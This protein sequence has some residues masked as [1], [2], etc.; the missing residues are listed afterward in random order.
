MFKN[1]ITIAF[2][3]LWKNKRFTAINILGLAI[4]IS[5]SLVIY[6]LVNYHFTFDKFEKDGGR[7]YRVV[8]NFSFSG[9]VY[10]NS[11]V[12]S[13]MGDAVQKEITGLEAVVPFRTWDGDT[14]V[15]IPAAGDKQ[16]AI[17][18]KQNEIIFADKRYFDLIS[19]Q[20]VA[21]SA[22]TALHQPYQTVL[23]ET[24]AKLYFPALAAAEV[25]GKEIYFNDTVRG[26]VAGVVKDIVYHT[27]FTFKTFISRATL[28]STSLKPDDWDAWNNTNGASQL[29]LK[30]SPGTSIARTEAAIN[31]LVDKYD[32]KEPGDNS[33]SEIKLQSLGDLHFNAEYGGYSNALASKPTMYSLLAVAAILLLLGCINF[34][35]LTTA[36]AAQRAG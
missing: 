10:R 29:F 3:T 6:L 31:N 13:P 22:A 35:N 4:G 26:I 34:I 18:K 12:R 27:D 24:N 32:K 9:E 20:W 8:S 14:K 16:P 15:T 36:H 23:T 2:R 30:L 28:E 7:I 21:G 33:T 5:A 11:G 17:F 1:Y 19:Y 25:I